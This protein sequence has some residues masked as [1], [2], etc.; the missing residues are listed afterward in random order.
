[1]ASPAA[2]RVWKAITSLVSWGRKVS[3]QHLAKTGVT[4]PDLGSKLNTEKMMPTK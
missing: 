1:M 3:T 2:S 4:C